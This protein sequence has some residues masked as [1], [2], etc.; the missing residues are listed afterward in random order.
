MAITAQD[1]ANDIRAELIEPL[2]AFFTDARLLVLINKGQYE[3]VRRARILEATALASTVAMQAQY[4]VPADFLGSLRVFY[5]DVQNGTDSWTPLKG[6]SV[7][8]MAQQYPNFLSTSNLTNQK[9]KPSNYFFIGNQIQLYP[10][11][12]VGNVSNNL[13]MI[14]ENRP[15]RL[16]SMTD[17]LV[18]DPSLIA[19]V[20]AF[21]LWRAWSQ[22][23]ED[24]KASMWK[25][26]FE[27]EVGRARAWKKLRQLD[28]RTALD[29]EAYAGRS[30]SGYTDSLG[31]SLN[32]LG[33]A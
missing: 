2:A 17:P 15:P 33:T 6:M 23:N 27:V 3:I 21:V 12:M 9:Q 14:Y 20:T 29:V 11:P 5:N 16:N 10:I 4:A 25:A 22:D 8:K 18:I 26:E 7:E 13:A 24:T 31:T 28:S 30:Y 19:A 32:P 1:V